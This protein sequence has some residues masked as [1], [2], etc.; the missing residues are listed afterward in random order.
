V[1]DKRLKTLD[2][3]EIVE[4]FILTNLAHPF[5]DMTQLTTSDWLA[6]IDD[7]VESRL[8]NGRHIFGKTLINMVLKVPSDIGSAWFKAPAKRKHRTY[9]KLSFAVQQRMRELARTFVFDNNNFLD[10]LHLNVPRKKLLA[11][12]L[13]MSLPA[14]PRRRYDL[15]DMYESPSYIQSMLEH[16][17]MI[18]V[19]KLR[20]DPDE[21]MRLLAEKFSDYPAMISE[22][23]DYARNDSKFKDF[24][25]I[26][27]SNELAIIADLISLGTEM[28]SI[29]K[30]LDKDV[31]KGLKAL[32]DFGSRLT[33][34]ISNFNFELVGENRDNSRFIGP[35]LFI[36]A[37][38]ALDPTLNDK[39]NG[40]LEL[41]ILKDNPNFNM[42][43]YLDG[44]R[45]ELEDILVSQ[46]IAD[47]E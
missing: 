2:L 38:K 1:Q 26:T 46:M 31:E 32:S 40:Y 29:K 8:A 44:E 7:Y 39:T 36:T 16:N 20:L 17:L 22:I 15:D 33:K 9:N 10:R 6:Q 3:Q 45:P 43:S 24:M 18:L 28:S 34:R 25:R 11:M 4:P 23:L 21:D 12:M 37:S 13:Y 35:E 14:I 41:I 30:L 5:K 27:V 47:L 42:E 19:N